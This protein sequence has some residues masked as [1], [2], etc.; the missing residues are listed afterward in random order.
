MDNIDMWIALSKRNPI[1][2]Y[3][4]I[5]K[6][7]SSHIQALT[8]KILFFLMAVD[9][10]L[11]KISKIDYHFYMR[12]EKILY[13]ILS[14]IFREEHCDIRDY[15]QAIFILDFSKLIYRFTCAKK[16]KEIDESVCQFR[17]NSWGRDYVKNCRKVERTKY[18]KIICYIREYI[19][20]NSD[21]YSQ[22]TT[23]LLNENCIDTIKKINASLRIQLLS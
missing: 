9:E 21:L 20:D 12:D 7:E 5:I 19:N 13:S 17:L 23:L 15:E 18:Q 1:D 3:E 4:L 14:D 22:L 8:M 2:R 6:D 11:V 10:I 16:F